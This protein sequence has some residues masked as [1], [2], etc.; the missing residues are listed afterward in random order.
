[1]KTL[2]VI[3]YGDRYQH[4]L[5]IHGDSARIDIKSHHHRPNYNSGSGYSIRH[6]NSGYPFPCLGVG[7]ASRRRFYEFSLVQ[8]LHLT[9]AHDAAHSRAR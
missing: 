5:G 7:N 4:T 8:S 6:G 3:C 9:A 1:M 2:L